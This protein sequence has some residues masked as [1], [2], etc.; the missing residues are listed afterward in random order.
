MQLNG[1]KST[2]DTT[3]KIK[4][5]RNSIDSQNSKKL[6][7]LQNNKTNSN[8]SINTKTKVIKKSIF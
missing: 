1:K 3:E 8:G 6:K 4:S 2:L 7:I 5:S